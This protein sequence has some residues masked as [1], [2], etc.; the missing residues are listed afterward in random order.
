MVAATGTTSL[1]AAFK[2]VRREESKT[3]R[4]VGDTA[5]APEG[6]HPKIRTCEGQGASLCSSSLGLGR[7]VANDLQSGSVAHG[8]GEDS[9]DPSL[10]IEAGDAGLIIFSLP[11][12]LEM[13]ENLC[14]N[15]CLRGSAGGMTWWMIFCASAGSQ[16]GDW[17]TH[18]GPR[19]GGGG[20]GPP[21]LSPA[22]ASW[23]FPRRWSALAARTWP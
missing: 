22:S 15:L 4:L 12:V 8:G 13:V 18:P 23:A 16:L 5:R 21:T 2:R 14:G 20:G 11:L 9:F 10:R 1:P 6:A 7:R 17:E 19:G 3:A